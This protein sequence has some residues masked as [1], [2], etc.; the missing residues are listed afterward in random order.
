MNLLPKCRVSRPPLPVLR[1]GE[2]M[3]LNI[4]YEIS[5]VAPIIT[6][7]P[8]AFQQLTIPRR[9]A[10]LTDDGGGAKSSEGES[11]ELVDL[12]LRLNSQFPGDIGVFCP[13][14]LNYITLQPGEAIFLGAGEPHAYIYGECM[15]CMANSDNVIRAGLTPKLRDVPNLVATL[16]YESSKASKHMVSPRPLGADSKFSTLYDPPIPEF[17]VIKADILAGEIEKHPKLDGP[18]I[19]I[20][21]EG[22]GSIQ[23]TGGEERDLELGVGEVFYVGAGTE[24]SIRAGGTKCVVY[25]A[26]AED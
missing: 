2:Q 8:L 4:T 11:Q 16:T 1:S 13:F 26:F 22:R 3:A 25:R 17:S 14:L 19:V 6:T 7:L 15:E 24:I 23:W 21:T 12:V 20:V 5:P 18:S 9:V 10:L